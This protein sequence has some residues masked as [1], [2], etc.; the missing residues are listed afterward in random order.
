MITRVTGVLSRAEDEEVRLQIGAFEYQVMV[1]EYLRRVLQHKLGQELTLHTMHYFD[2]DPSRGKVVPRLVGFLSEIDLDFFELFCTVDGV[3]TRKALKA[4]VRSAKE[5]A[6]AIQRQDTKWLTSLP[7]VGAS[8]AEKIVATLK[9]KVTRYAMA[10]TPKVKEGASADAAEE[11]A[12]TAVVDGN[13][14]EEAYEALCALGHSPIEARNRLD[15][16]L[17]TGKTFTSA[18]EVLRF[19]YNK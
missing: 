9:R 18:E 7:G 16:V 11:P 4:L 13:V 1:P 2:G 14:L 3:G 17:A 10:P 8:T 12:P 15:K 6:D 5:V 19:I